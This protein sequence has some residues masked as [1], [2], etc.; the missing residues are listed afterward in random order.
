MR[1]GIYHVRF[2][3]SVGRTGEGLVVMKQGS[4][5]G[6]DTGYLYTGQFNVNGDALSGRLHIKRWNP[7]QVS[8]FGPLEKFDLSLSGKMDTGGKNF[9][10]S[11]TVSGQP[12]LTISISGS[13]ISEAS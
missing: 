8:V 10:V 13:H 11:G 7:G 1:D 9:S 6:G 5:N 12:G 3:S 4:A 2:S